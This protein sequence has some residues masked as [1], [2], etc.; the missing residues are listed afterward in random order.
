M[1]LG[2]KEVVLRGMASVMS[3]HVRNQ[4]VSGHIS[5]FEASMDEH[6]PERTFRNF[7]GFLMRERQVVQESIIDL[8]FLEQEICHLC[9]HV[10]IVSFVGQ[11]SDL[12]GIWLRELQELL[13]LGQI[14]L[15][16]EVG[17]GFSY[18]RLDSAATTRQLLELTPHKFSK[19]IAMF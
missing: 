6:L 7:H 13:A 3:V 5:P 18:I 14:L 15:H 8:R 4:V 17:W 12:H 2:Y 9:N 11:G 16:K 1:A 19:G 10:V